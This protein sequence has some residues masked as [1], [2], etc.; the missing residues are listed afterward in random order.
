AETWTEAAATASGKAP[1]RWRRE[2]PRDRVLGRSSNLDRRSDRGHVSVSAGHPGHIR[3]SVTHVLIISRLRRRYQSIAVAM[4]EVGRER[5]QTDGD[6]FGA[7]A[8]RG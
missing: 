5:R 1:R 3:R 7:V 8:G 2:R 6:I 4:G